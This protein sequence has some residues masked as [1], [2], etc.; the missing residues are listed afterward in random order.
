MLRTIILVVVATI[1]CNPIIVQAPPA[2]TGSPALQP[3][4]SVF[5]KGKGPDRQC[6]IVAVLDF[7]S[8]ADSEDK[9][10]EELRARAAEAGADAVIDAE[11]EH[12]EGGERSHLSGLAVRF[13]VRDARAYDVL[14]HIVIESDPNGAD[15]GFGA[16]RARAKALGADKIVDVKFDH[17][18]GGEPSRL[19]GTAVRYR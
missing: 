4:L 6:E 5:P 16:L 14:D 11:F 12:G 9:G 1:G 10:F 13:K 7:H 17:G 18:E 15:K 3:Q 2:T 19:T 8:D